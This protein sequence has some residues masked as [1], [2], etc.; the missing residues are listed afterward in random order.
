MSDD[1]AVPPIPPAPS[2]GSVPPPIAEPAAAPTPPASPAA[3]PAA[4]P[5]AASPASPYAATPPAANPYA[6]NP[7]A[8]ATYGAPPP[9]STGRRVWDV[10][11]TVILLVLGLFGMLL[12][13]LMAAVLPLTIADSGGFADPNL[14][15]GDQAVI[16]ISH[17]V[18]YAAAATVSIILLVRCKIAFWV[19]LTAG[20]IAAIIFWATFVGAMIASGA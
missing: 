14:I 3:T 2:T 17:L 16:I 9:A 10:V 6:A 12:G 18:L 7:Y 15:A 4:A 5:A 11:L 8:T 1:A 19:P 20:I 13:L